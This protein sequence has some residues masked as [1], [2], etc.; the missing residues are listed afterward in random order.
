MD[1][2]VCPVCGGSSISRIQRE[3]IVRESFG[4]QK[5][6]LLNEYT[7]ESCGST[8]DFF[9]ENET[10]IQNSLSVLKNDAIVNI[11]EYFSQQKISLSSMERAL[12]LP[13]RTLT[14]WKNKA[15]K[16][17]STGVA[18]LKFLRVFPWLL[19]VAENKYDYTSAQKIHMAIAFKE[20]LRHMTFDENAY[21]GTEMG[22][23]ANS[24][25]LFVRVETPTTGL[26]S[27]REMYQGSPV[28]QINMSYD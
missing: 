14:K 26:A 18:L 28:P 13:Q 12:E 11:L 17:S 20:M 10:S 23:P 6:I 15:S 3:E 27:G 1:N 16:P 4:G 7:C 8:G 2:R 9:N 25:C 19:D 21:S 22:P 24:V 5:T